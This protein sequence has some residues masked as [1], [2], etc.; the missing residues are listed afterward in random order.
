MGSV[1]MRSVIG[2][3]VHV[4]ARFH[5]SGAQFPAE[6]H[7]GDLRLLEVGCKHFLV[8]LGMD[9]GDWMGSDV[10]QSIDAVAAKESQEIE[11]LVVGMPDGE[12]FLRHVRSIPQLHGNR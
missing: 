4:T 5:A 7:V 2:A 6:K 9:P 1:A 8:E 3:S 10:H 12:E 11:H